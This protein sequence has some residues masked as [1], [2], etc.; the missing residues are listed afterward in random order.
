MLKAVLVILIAISFTS[1]SVFAEPSIE[2]G[3]SSKNIKSL[4]S[5]LVSG[6]ITGVSEFRPVKLTVMDP[7]GD[8]VYSPSVKISGGEF[9]KLLHPTLPSF[10]AGTY[11]VTASHENTEITAQTQFTVTAQEIPRNPI[12]QPIQEPTIDESEIVIQ[13]GITVSADAVIGSDTINIIGNT[14]MLGIDITL[15]VNSPTGNIISIAQTT[16]DSF[17]NFEVKIKTGG[18]MW[19]EDGIYTITVNQSGLLEYKES[20]QVEIKEGVVVPEFGVIASLILAISIISI[21]IVSS[22]SKLNILPRY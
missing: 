14:D 13:G 10:K 21:I 22:K 1:T 20:V 5:V 8:I 6:K 9:K 18:A 2:I 7:D 3:V 4:D 15:V 19:K 11:T 16:P 12:K 17:G